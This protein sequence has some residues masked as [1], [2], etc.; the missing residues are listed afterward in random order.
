MASHVTKDGFDGVK[1]S[2]AFSASFHMYI[3]CM[4]SDNVNKEGHL[5]AASNVLTIQLTFMCYMTFMSR[6]VTVP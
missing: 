3:I 6:T 5:S 1:I 4:S 2:V